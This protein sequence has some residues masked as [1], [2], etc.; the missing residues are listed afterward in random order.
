ML[1]DVDGYSS[2]II[3]VADLRIMC[4]PHYCRV[5]SVDS[6]AECTVSPLVGQLERQLSP[7]IEHRPAQAKKLSGAA[8]YLGSSSGLRERPAW[9]GIASSFDVEMLAE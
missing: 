8:T 5:L 4:L 7:I 6:A 3:R 1:L 2:R 9:R